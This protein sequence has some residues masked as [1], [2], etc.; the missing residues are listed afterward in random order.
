MAKQGSGRR[1]SKTPPASKSAPAKARLRSTKPMAAA[2]AAAI[3][4][5]LLSTPSSQRLVLVAVVLLLA[6]WHAPSE[7][8]FTNM[9]RGT[10][11]VIVAFCATSVVALPPGERQAGRIFDRIGFSLLFLYCMVL[12]FLVF[13][14]TCLLGCCSYRTRLL[15]FLCRMRTQREARFC[16]W[17]LP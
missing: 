6:A 16:F 1:R 11:S 9:Q 8:P 4:P 15:L 2:A 10:A 3:K 17:T 7:K 14:V 5:A 12:L 13:Q